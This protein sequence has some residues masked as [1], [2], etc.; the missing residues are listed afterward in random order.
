MTSI[1]AFLGLIF[2]IILITSGVQ[3]YN[4]RAKELK[5][6]NLPFYLPA[7]RIRKDGIYILE[8]KRQIITFIVIAFLP[9]GKVAWCSDILLDDSVVSR[10]RFEVVISEKLKNPKFWSASETINNKEIIAHFKNFHHD[11]YTVFKHED[12]SITCMAKRDGQLQVFERY[13]DDDDKPV[14]NWY[15]YQ[16]FSFEE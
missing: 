8:D 9:N 16:F 6:N 15:E 5:D 3:G 13:I 4:N 12:I 11:S 7:N 2:L 10:L 14:T 1:L